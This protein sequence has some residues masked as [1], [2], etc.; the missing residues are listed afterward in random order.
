LT[1]AFSGDGM[2]AVRENIC[3]VIGCGGIRIYKS[4]E[5]NK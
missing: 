2:Y 1:E 5:Y 3:I 4:L